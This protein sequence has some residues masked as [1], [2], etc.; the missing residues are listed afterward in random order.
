MRA[1]KTKFK[2][3]AVTMKRKENLFYKYNFYGNLAYLNS[4]VMM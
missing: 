2:M 1:D 4:Y 3:K